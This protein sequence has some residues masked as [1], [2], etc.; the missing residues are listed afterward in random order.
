MNKDF[1][2]FIKETI[3]DVFADA[4]DE[5]TSFR[6]ELD[7]A[8]PIS[9]QDYFT[10]GGCYTLAKIVKHFCPQVILM[11]RDLALRDFEHCVVSFE[12]DLYDAQGFVED[13]ENYKV[14]TKADLDYM[15]NGGFGNYINKLNNVPVSDYI[16][17]YIEKECNMNNQIEC[18]NASKENSG[19]SI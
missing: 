4:Y 1:E 9:G 6:N 17:N 3:P 12:G 14:A 13:S 7:L 16:A 2:W 8:K 19:R 5:C 11:I 10:H 18:I 15:E